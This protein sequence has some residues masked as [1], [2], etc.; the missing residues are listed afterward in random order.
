MNIDLGLSVTKEHV[1]Q[2]KVTVLEQ[3]VGHKDFFNFL[4]ILILFSKIWAGKFVAPNAKARSSIKGPELKIKFFQSSSIFHNKI[5]TWFE[6][7]N[8]YFLLYSHKMLLE[9]KNC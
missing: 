1:S 3:R 6:P 7:H 5:C 8:W 9:R 4:A 2:T